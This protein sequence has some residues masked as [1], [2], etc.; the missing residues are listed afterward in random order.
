MLVAVHRGEQG[1]P[2]RRQ[3]AG[4]G[5]H[6]EEVEQGGVAGVLGAVVDDQHGQR[7]AGPAA[8]AA[9]EVF[10]DAALD[11]ALRAGGS[12]EGARDTLRLRVVV[13]SGEASAAFCDRVA[14]IVVVVERRSRVVVVVVVRGGESGCVVDEFAQGRG[15]ISGDARGG[16]CVLLLIYCCSRC[17][18]RGWALCLNF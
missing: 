11:G 6:G 2:H 18:Q 14:G 10:R 9:G 3:A 12:A 15:G 4:D 5:G 13:V 1:G 7:V 8:A 16:T 17:H